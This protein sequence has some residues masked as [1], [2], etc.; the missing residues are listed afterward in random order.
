MKT[1]RG[2]A[3]KHRR[4]V[5]KVFY[6]HRTLNRANDSLYSRMGWLPDWKQKL[7]TTLQGL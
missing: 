5:M 6:R 3:R 4:E 1:T 2:T 7:A